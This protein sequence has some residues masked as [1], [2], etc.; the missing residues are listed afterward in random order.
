MGCFCSGCLL[1]LLAMPANGAESAA[2]PVNEI[3]VTAQKREQKVMDVPAAITVLNESRIADYGANR[4][5]GLQYM[6]PNL[7]MTQDKPS[8]VGVF[9]RGVGNNTR[10]VGTDMRAGVYLDGVY[11]GRSQAV[12]LETLGLER[13]EVMRGPQGTLFG[14]NTV[15]GAINLI[16]GKPRETFGGTVSTTVGQLDQV[17]AHL[18]LNVPLGGRGIFLQGDVTSN[19]KRGYVR[20]V[21]AGKD[22][23]GAD[24]LSGRVKLRYKPA[25]NFD[26]NLALDWFDEDAPAIHRQAVTATRNH[27][28]HDTAEIDSRSVRGAALS[29]DYTLPGQYLLSSISA[30][31]ESSFRSIYDE[32][33]LPLYGAESDFNEDNLLLTQELRLSSPLYERHDYLAGLYLYGSSASSEREATLGPATT[34][35]MVL[36]AHSD[37][38]VDNQSAALY[39]H[40]NYRLYDRVELSG[41]VR[42]T[43]EQKTF[44]FEQQDLTGLFITLPEAYQDRADI[45]ELTME[46]GLKYH[47]GDFSLLYAKYSSGFKSGGWNADF[48]S[49]IEK[50]PFGPEY[51]D[52]FE[53]GLKDSFFDGLI[54]AEIAVFHARYG[55]YQV[56][57]F[58][59]DSKGGTIIVASNA[60]EVSSKGLEVELRSTFD[61]L[62]VALSAGI[63]DAK[64]EEYR[65]ANGPGIDLDGERIGSARGNFNVLVSHH[66]GK[67]PRADLGAALE[68]SYRLSEGNKGVKYTVDSTIP[69]YGI[70]NARVSLGFRNSGLKLLLWGKNIA[71]K[72][73]LVA[74][75]ASFLGTA[76]WL[77]GEPRT[78]GVTASYDF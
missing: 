69:G 46:A 56:Q 13:V 36:P 26:A 63:N 70:V 73:Y 67:W 47:L 18:K 28:A 25:G 44:A 2:S 39:F 8:S 11:L 37:A 66:Y 6:V 19:R 4:M 64:Y 29:V 78:V 50:L 71:D 55:D 60:G 24:S 22:L 7:V 76:R 31:R 38:E 51:V 48:I 21:Y 23:N 41:G 17:G 49:S 65:D 34:G 68:Y 27:V 72:S 62:A 14:M 45:G 12:N 35:G 5:A 16:T 75:D 42:Y 52:G 77:Y 3:T 54:D 40:G 57:Q 43:W 58:S 61:S 32:D 1:L 33:Y 74:R 30:Y 59:M 15:S 53:F 20:N 10:N 9:I